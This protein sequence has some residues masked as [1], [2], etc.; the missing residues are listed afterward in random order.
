MAKRV[1]EIMN[2][3]LFTV[4]PDERV[5]DVRGWLVALG[6]SAA[7]V[8]DDARK[9]I[10]FVSLRDVLG[11]PEHNH[12]HVH[13]SAPAHGVAATATIEEAARRMAETDHHHLVC[14]DEE[15]RAVG[16]VG[17]LDV[18]RGLIGA[19]VRHPDAFPHYDERTG[20]SWSDEVALTLEGAEE[21]P[22]GP[23]IYV[24]IA[25]QAGVEDRVVWSEATR[26]VRTRLIDILSIPQTAPPHLEPDLGR[27]ALRFRA[28]S[29]P[30]ARALHEAV[31][32]I[33]EKTPPRI[34]ME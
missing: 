21:A 8:I 4:A 13:M 11:A 9:P 29:A 19:P 33:L 16:F 17:S 31:T 2:H 26:N 34:A 10:G 1:Q 12:V 6:V 24:L 30:S 18:I 25:G 3:E 14:V 23:G 28:A 15:G 5:E 27:G 7:P 22:D 20:L 32:H